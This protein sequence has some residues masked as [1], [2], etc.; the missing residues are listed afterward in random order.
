MPEELETILR[1]VAEGHLTPEEASPIIDALTRR[2]RASRR[3]DRRRRRRSTKLRRRVRRRTSTRGSA[4]ASARTSGRLERLGERIDRKVDAA[5]RAG[6]C[7]CRGRASAGRGA[8]RD[9][10][11]VAAARWR[12]PAAHQDHRAWPAGGEPAHPD[13]LRRDR[14]Q[15]RA[16]ASAATRA[17]AF[18][19]PSAPARSGRSSTSRTPTAR[20]ACSSAWSRT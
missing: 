13:R 19:M 12:P 8:L 20:A 1:L 18:A 9:A 11:Q 5:N 16:R 4:P 10:Q 3:G 7:P 14:P 15:L 6:A 17:S 2:E